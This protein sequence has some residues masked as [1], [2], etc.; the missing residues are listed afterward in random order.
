MKKK[1]ERRAGQK[2]GGET[3]AN[4]TRCCDLSRS[5]VRRIVAIL[6]HVIS[7][8]ASVSEDYG[9]TCRRIREKIET[10]GKKGW[11]DREIEM[12]ERRRSKGEKKKKK[13]VNLGG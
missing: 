8:T 6:F 1:E 11:K 12:D 3:D 5:C 4:V 9:Q 7:F 10:L 13:A 2:V